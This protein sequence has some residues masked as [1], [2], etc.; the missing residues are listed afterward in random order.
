MTF[1]GSGFENRAA[2]PH[3]EFPGAP[4]GAAAGAVKYLTLGQGGVKQA[5]SKR[6][7][8]ARCERGPLGTRDRGR[9]S[10]S[11]TSRLPSRARKTGKNSA[12]SAGYSRCGRCLRGE[13]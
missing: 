13:G 11:L 1:F 7:P 3:K 5:K 10:S 9:R 8:T 6:S 12:C 4:P 2:H